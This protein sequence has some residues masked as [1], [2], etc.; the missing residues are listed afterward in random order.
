M[1]QCVFIEGLVVDALIGIL[2]DERVTKQPIEL[3]LKCYFDFSTASQSDN[4]SDTIDYADVTEQLKK[5]V[6]ATQFQLIEKLATSICAWLFENY[7]IEKIQL[8]LTKPSA[9]KDANVG[10]II[11]RERNH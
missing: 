11:E 8:R 3:D 2:P 10:V 6:A 5:Y 7:A 4:F 9:L 1:N